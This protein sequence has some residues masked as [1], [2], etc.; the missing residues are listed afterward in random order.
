MVAHP[1]TARVMSEA[2]LLLRVVVACNSTLERL[3]GSQN[4][5]RVARETSIRMTGARA[6]ARTRLAEIRGAQFTAV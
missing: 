2:V 6:R 4:P 5:A 1:P 3:D